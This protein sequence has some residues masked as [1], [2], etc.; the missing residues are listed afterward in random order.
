M[1]ELCEHGA[2]LLAGCADDEDGV[3]DGGHLEIFGTVD[4]FFWKVLR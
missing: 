2:A 3:G 1:R 4:F